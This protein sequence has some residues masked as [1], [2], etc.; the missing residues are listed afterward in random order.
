MMLYQRVR[1]VADKVAE[2]QA[3]LARGLDVHVRTFSNYLKEERQD[4]LWPLLEKIC[5]LYPQIRREWLW[6]GEGEMLKSDAP[7]TLPEPTPDMTAELARM[8]IELDEVN[9]INRQLVTKLLVD[10]VGDKDAQTNTAK[11]ADGA[12]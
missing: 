6:W 2:S 7:L 4:N 11:T 10:G 3:D 9:K 8:R 5:V 12:K 1:E